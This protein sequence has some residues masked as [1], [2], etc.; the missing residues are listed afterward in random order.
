MRPANT[1]WRLF[2]WLQVL[3]RLLALNKRPPLAMAG[4]RCS[5]SA[6]PVERVDHR[7]WSL[8]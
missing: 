7:C 2:W 6:L 4:H 8:C 5:S 3:L 1:P